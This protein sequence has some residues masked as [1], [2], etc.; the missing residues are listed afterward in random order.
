MANFVNINRS[1]LNTGF[2]SLG[3][4]F[5]PVGMGLSGN[6]RNQGGYKS[7]KGRNVNSNPTGIAPGH[8]RPLTNL[9]PGNVFPAPFGKARPLKQYRKGRVI[10]NVDIITLEKNNDGKF[11]YKNNQYLSE[12]ELGLIQFNL[13]RNVKSSKGT[14]L[15]GGFGGS[16]LLNEM[17]DKPGGYLVKQNRID[18]VDESGKLIEDCTTCQGVGI[19]DTYYPNKFYLT[20]NPEPNTQNK[21]LCCNQEK[22]ARKRVIYAN[23]YLPKNY[24]TTH[25]QYLQNR[26]KT[27]KQKAFNFERYNPIN[28]AEIAASPIPGITAALIKASK[29]GDPFTITNT[30]F[31]NCQPNAEIAAASEINLLYALLDILLKQNGISKD[32]YDSFIAL[33]KFKFTVLFEYLQNLSKEKRDVAIPIFIAYVDNPYYGI[34]FSGPNNPIGCKLTVYKPNNPRYAKQGAVESSTRILKLNVDTI[35]KNAASYYTDG[36]GKYIR[37]T[38]TSNLVF[39]NVPFLYKN[40]A[41]RYCE[42]PPLN[43]TPS[44]YQN[45][46]ACRYIKKPDYYYPVS[47]SSPYKFLFA[48]KNPVG[49][50]VVA[51]GFL[52]PPFSR[53]TNHYRQSPN[54][55]TLL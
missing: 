22:F 53:L 19:V 35:Q 21:I 25:A 12:T 41:A 49:D 18:E 23:T 5:Y 3:T 2:N 36:A 20:E 9:D 38:D 4:S 14:S 43:F 46:K 10:P 17:Q 8:I 11:I 54:N 45:K 16:G 6:R 13:N 39:S 26:C 7:W 40:K 47:Q 55:N 29:P 42:K 52:N 28:A 32:E 24:Y 33:N 31:A 27:Y 30:Y 1:A 50:G 44:T 51:H 34:P 37:K 48:V 15:G